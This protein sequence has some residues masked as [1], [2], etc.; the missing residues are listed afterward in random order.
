[1]MNSRHIFRMIISSISELV[2]VL[3]GCLYKKTGRAKCTYFKMLMVIG[4]VQ[5]AINSRPPTYRSSENDLEVISSSSSLK[6]NTIPY[7][8]MRQ[9]NDSYLENQGPPY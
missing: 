8:M 5:A 4:D 9:P 7:L 6:F 1:M 3:P 2:C